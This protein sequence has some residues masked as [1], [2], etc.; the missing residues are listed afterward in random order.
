M[1]TSF[2]HAME[3]DAGSDGVD[4]GSPAALDDLSEFTLGLLVWWDH[5]SGIRLISKSNSDGTQGWTSQLTTGSGSVFWSRQRDTIPQGRGFNAAIPASA[6]RWVFIRMANDALFTGRIG[7]Y[8][9]A[10]SAP[11]YNSSAV[12][13]GTYTSDAS[14]NWRLGQ[15]NGSNASRVA[16]IA[17]VGVWSGLLTDGTIDNYAAD[18]DGNGGLT[19]ALEYLKPVA[20]D[21]ASITGGKSLLAGSYSGVTLVDGPDPAS[22]GSPFRAYFNG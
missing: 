6:W 18:M 1:P 22:S 14:L 16:R 19:A 20:S 21:T 7:V 11:G 2:T 5:T 17:F 13:S 10:L 12:G 8:G 9:S 4:L 15:Q 3:F